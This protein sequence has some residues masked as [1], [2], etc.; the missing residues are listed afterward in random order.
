MIEQ[1]STLIMLG[2]FGLYSVFGIL[3]WSLAATVEFVAYRRKAVDFLSSA[4]SARRTVFTAVITTLCSFGSL[5]LWWGY[6]LSSMRHPDFRWL[7]TCTVFLVCLFV[8][9]WSLTLYLRVQ[10]SHQPYLYRLPQDADALRLG[11]CKNGIMIAASLYPKIVT[12]E[13]TVDTMSRAA[14]VSMRREVFPMVKQRRNLKVMKFTNDFEVYCNVCATGYTHGYFGF[15][16]AVQAAPDHL[17]AERV[18]LQEWPETKESERLME[19]LALQFL[20]SK[21]EE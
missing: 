12:D 3:V 11:Q 6:L 13:D 2:L 4:L 17:Q 8:V 10:T 14:S 20:Q 7:L 19:A 15:L 9:L 5:A 21:E 18:I 16:A 1:I